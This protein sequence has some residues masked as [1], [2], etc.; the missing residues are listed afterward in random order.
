MAW[1]DS[2][3]IAQVCAFL[4]ILLTTNTRLSASTLAQ[5]FNLLLSRVMGLKLSMASSLFGC[6]LNNITSAFHT[7]VGMRFICCVLQIAAKTGANKP[8]I[9]RRGMWQ[10]LGICAQYAFHFLH[11]NQLLAKLNILVRQARDTLEISLKSCCVKNVTPRKES[12]K[13]Y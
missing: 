10:I 8:D 6:F 7:H 11:H 12:A 3:W 4:T 5:S 1:I 9:V 2:P 13:C